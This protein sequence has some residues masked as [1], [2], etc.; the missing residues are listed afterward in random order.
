MHKYIV[1]HTNDKLVADIA[2]R[3]LYESN[4]P[5]EQQEYYNMSNYWNENCSK[6]TFDTI[7]II[8]IGGTRLTMQYW[9]LL[10]GRIVQ[11]GE[12]TYAGH[13]I[14]DPI[15]SKDYPGYYHI[16]SV[17]TYVLARDG[18]CIGL[19]NKVKLKP[20][21]Y[22][23]RAKDVEKGRY[24]RYNLHEKYYPVH[25]LL[26][27]TFNPPKGEGFSP[28]LLQV[29][30]KDGIKDNNSLSNLEWCTPRENN[31]HAIQTGLMPVYGGGVEVLNIET[32]E[33]ISHDITYEIDRMFNLP[34]TTTRGRCRNTE[35]NGFKIF[36]NKYLF[37]FKNSSHPFPT[38]YTALR[39]AN[40]PINTTFLYNVFTKELTK[41]DYV[42]EIADITAVSA[43]HIS[44]YATG[45]R[46]QNVPMNGYFFYK[47]HTLPSSFP[48]YNDD[49]LA[50]IQLCKD[51][52]KQVKRG[53]KVTNIQTE[54]V[55][56]CY[57]L[58]EV[59]EVAG[60]A[61]NMA[62][63]DLIKRRLKDINFSCIEIL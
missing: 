63:K 20:H 13:W 17:E 53:Y 14:H 61:Y 37:R 31:W 32:G 29:N 25:R 36:E 12:D 4:Q 6:V 41:H 33:I 22:L 56:I 34:V 23:G 44:N 39:N 2:T 60:I 49:Q 38:N 16:P 18:S 8:A 47:E 51:R 1:P 3:T 48:E 57:D 43:T 28:F 52:N 50:Y 35:D 58:A 46:K 62:S 26:M 54:Q 21:A 7:G 40:K 59:C 11:V 5:I 19:R 10:E 45:Q 24:Q 55:F 9:H 30:H 15:E 27:M 42:I